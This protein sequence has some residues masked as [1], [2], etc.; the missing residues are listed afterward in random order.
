MT[1]LAQLMPMASQMVY[2]LLVSIPMKASL[3]IAV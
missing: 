2:T 1:S 3:G